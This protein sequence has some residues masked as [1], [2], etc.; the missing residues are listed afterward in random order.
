MTTQR[1][2]DLG[3]ERGTSA[4]SWYFDGNTNDASYAIVLQGIEDCDPEILDTFPSFTFG[5]WAGE[6]RAEIFYDWAD[7]S[8]ADQDE[9]TEQYLVGFDEGMEAEITRIALYHVEG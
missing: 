4:G 6:S 9:A 2:Y 3:Y 8:N 5:E 7:M 1:A